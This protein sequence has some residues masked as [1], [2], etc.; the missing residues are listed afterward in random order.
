[1][2]VL[3]FCRMPAHYAHVQVASVVVRVG[4]IRAMVRPEATKPLYES[5]R[6]ARRPTT[7]R[8]LMLIE[9]GNLG[10]ILAAAR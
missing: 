6:K 9:S 10:C 4:C 1:M 7:T 8:T 5:A 2:I 3:G